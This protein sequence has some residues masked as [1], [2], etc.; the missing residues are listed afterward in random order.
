ME[1][2]I[3]SSN[4]FISLLL[5][6]SRRQSVEESLLYI[7]TLCFKNVISVDDYLQLI[8]IL[9][10]KSLKY[11]KLTNKLIKLMQ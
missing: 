10:R 4:T 3:A 11:V 6:E 9:S 7:K 2:R 1:A 5:W 8:R